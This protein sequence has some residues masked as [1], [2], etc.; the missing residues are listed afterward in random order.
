[1]IADHLRSTSFLIAD[2]VLPSNEG[3]GYVL[4][5]IM[6]RAMRHAHLL[7]A[8]DPVMWRLV[9]ALVAQMG[10]AFPELPRAQALIEET[11][12]SEETRFKATLERGLRM[13]DEELERLP[14]GEPLPG[15][16]AFRL[17]DT[18][19]FPIDLTQDALRE[20]GRGVDLAG[21]DAAMAEQKAKARAAWAGSGEAAD[22]GIW[23]DL[24]EQ[25]GATE[26][27]GYDTEQAEGQVL[28]LVV[29][30]ARR[31]ERADRGR[32]P[33]G[34]E[35]DAVLRRG[36]R[37]GR[38]QRHARHRQGAGRDQRRAQEGRG[39]RALRPGRG[40]RARTAA[41]R[42]SSWSTTRA[43]PP[44]APTTRRPTCCTRRCAGRSATTWRSAA[45]WSRPTG[46]ASTSRIRRR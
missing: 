20:K 37:P 5:R 32:G 12:L 45:A 16:T 18:Y 44:S 13:L 28:A 17:Y 41:P 7:G 15:A 33:G 21:F 40:R 3:R 43:A 1:M 24:G 4:R 9:P 34:A 23:Y 35:P 8:E 27:L 11:L 26:F 25:H 38:R 46:C 10:G 22:E 29:G 42:P 36:R 2:G 14:D 30:G 6:R 19:G 31:R 39:L